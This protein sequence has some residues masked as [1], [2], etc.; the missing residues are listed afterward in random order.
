MVLL[1]PGIPYIAV[2]ID[3]DIL[4]KTADL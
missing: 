3:A 1:F 4:A 2:I